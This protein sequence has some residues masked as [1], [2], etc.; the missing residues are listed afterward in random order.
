MGT[1]GQA[2]RMSENH[3]EI[4]ENLEQFQKICSRK[5]GGCDILSS[6]KYK[7][8]ARLKA[9][10]PKTGRPAVGPENGYTILE[11]AL[12]TKIVYFRWQK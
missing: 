9:A 10:P 11:F 1:K 6:H 2:I 4:L 8:M 5:N 12:D 3:L 7:S